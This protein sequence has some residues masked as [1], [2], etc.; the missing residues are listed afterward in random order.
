MRNGT[1]GLSG[2][3]ID[4]GNDY[5]LRFTP[6]ENSRMN[7]HR[8]SDSPPSTATMIIGTIIVQRVRAVLV[9]TTPVVT[10]V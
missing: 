9:G 10:C 8:T 2:F 5:A 4:R 3:N 7:Y 1:I 6:T